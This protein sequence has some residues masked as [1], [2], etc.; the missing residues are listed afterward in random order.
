MS[1]AMLDRNIAWSMPRKR[2]IDIF[3]IGWVKGKGLGF[4]LHPIS[5][6]LV[7]A[8]GS[9]NNQSCI[10]GIVVLEENF[11]KWLLR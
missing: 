10:M 5:T 3:V 9:G 11:R 4:I 1:L 2:F 8:V 6:I 7:I